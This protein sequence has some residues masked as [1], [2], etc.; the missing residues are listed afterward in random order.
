MNTGLRYVIAA[1]A[2]VALA[3]AAIA[4]LLPPDAMAGPCVLNGGAAMLRDLPEASGLAV[5]RRDPRLLWSHNDSGNEPILFALDATGAMRGRI[6]LGVTLRDW[7]DVSA[8]RWPAG[9]CLYIADIGN[10]DLS[11]RRMPIYR[12]A[13]PDPHDTRTATPE[14]F[15]A[16][17]PDG[18]HNAEALVVVGPDIIVITRD[19]VGALYRARLPESPGD[20]PLQRVGQL[21]L[22]AVTD[23]EASP[24][25]QSVVVRTSH[26]AVN[27]R[28]ADFVH[29]GN[30]PAGLHIP[31]DGLREPQGEGVALGQGGM[32]YLASEQ[33]RWGREGQLLSLRCTLPE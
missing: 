16:I 20:V 6:R 15:L 23:A 11:R 13:E 25:G 28:A 24:D 19:R 12:V 17:Y 22:T 4:A 10:N 9:D 2:C 26:E 33:A 32:L 14:R 27:Y 31:I 30:V 5:S 18:P 21:G 8:G 3:F 7:E 29:G 1:T